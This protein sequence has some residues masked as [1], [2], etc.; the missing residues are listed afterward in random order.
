VGASGADDNGYGNKV[1]A[2]RRR[3]ALASGIPLR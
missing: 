3:I 2:E 1:L